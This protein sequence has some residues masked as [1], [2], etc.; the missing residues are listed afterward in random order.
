MNKFNR[1]KNYISVIL[2]GSY[3]A[4]FA[5]NIL[6]YHKY[7]ID[8]EHHKSIVENSADGSSESHGLNFELQCPVHN[9]YTSLHNLLISSSAVSPESVYSNETL[10]ISEINFFPQKEFLSSNSLRAPP[11]LFS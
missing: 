10:N 11:A 4:L 5:F 9:N 8:F 2:L 1:N 3:F 6:H 7:K